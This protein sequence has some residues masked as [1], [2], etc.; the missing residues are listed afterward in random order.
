MSTLFLLQTYYATI[1]YVTFVIT[2]LFAYIL[3]DQVIYFFTKIIPSDFE[4]MGIR[5]ITAFH[6][7]SYIGKI[8]G[9]G[10][11]LIGL[12]FPK[13]NNNDEMIDDKD[14]DDED[15]GYGFD[16]V[17]Y[18]KGIMIG[19]CCFSVFVQLL[20]VIYFWINTKKFAERPIRRLV[21]SK[22]TRKISRT[23]F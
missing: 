12:L 11:S 22:N 4:L 8:F 5:G 19:T 3:D 13:N 14:Y 9:S 23:E 15:Y 17:T 7:M 16:K 20:L 1:Y 10:I 2:V 18:E 21:A 6:L